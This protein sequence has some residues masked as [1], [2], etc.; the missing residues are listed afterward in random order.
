MKLIYTGVV[1]PWLCDA[2]GHFTTRH[3]VAMFDD[4]SYRLLFEACGFAGSIG[5]FEGIGWVDAKQSYEYQAE[6]HAGAL[7]EIHG[8]IQKLGNSSI[9]TRYEMRNA[10]SGE[11]AATHDSVSIMF[12]LNARKS[13]RIPDWARE[14]IEKSACYSAI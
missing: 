2:M 5:D 9:T 4:A 13:L 12:D 8:A 11:C 6:Q 10:A 7:I 14:R 3:Y 1:H